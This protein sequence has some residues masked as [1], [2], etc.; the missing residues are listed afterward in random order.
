V[1]AYWCTLP[2]LVV[3]VLFAVGCGSVCSWLLFYFRLMSR[4]RVVMCRSTTL[5]IAGFDCPNTPTKNLNDFYS[6]YVELKA[7]RVNA[8]MTFRQHL[9]SPNSQVASLVLQLTTAPVSFSS[10]F[11]YGSL[12]YRPTPERSRS[13]LRVSKPVSGVDNQEKHESLEGKK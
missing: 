9:S 6:G 3:V 13:V 1:D 2:D 10:D 5:L 11:L 7:E 12:N 8:V 4:S